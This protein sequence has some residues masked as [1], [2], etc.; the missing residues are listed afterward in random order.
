MI[1]STFVFLVKLF[2]VSSTIYTNLSDDYYGKGSQ[3]LPYS[4]LEE[5]LND[6][7]N[8]E[9]T[10]FIN[11]DNVISN[12]VISVPQ[13]FMAQT[14][15][16]NIGL[17]EVI[18]GIYALMDIQNT[19]NFQNISIVLNNYFFQISG[20]LF[21]ANLNITTAFI[22]SQS[23]QALFE[24]FETG[25]LSFQNVSFYDFPNV[26]QKAVITMNQ[27]AK[28]EI[29]N[30]VF[31]DINVSEAKFLIAIDSFVNIEN[32]SFKNF[33]SDTFSALFDL[34]DSEFNFTNSQFIMGIF[35]MLFN[36][37]LENPSTTY[38]ISISNS[39]FYNIS[40]SSENLGLS[41]IQI[42]SNPFSNIHLENL[43]FSEITLNSS[44][45]M[46]S[47]GQFEIDIIN[48]TLFRTTCQI[49]ISIIASLSLYLVNSSF[50]SNNFL[51]DTSVDGTLLTFLDVQEKTLDHLFIFDSVSY[52]TTPGIKIL[53][54]MNL[55]SF[56]T[57]VINNSYFQNLTTYF[58][59]E[60]EVGVVFY[61]SSDKENITLENCNFLNNLILPMLDAI[62]QL[63]DPC[64]R[65]MGAELNLTI[66][67][68][69]FKNNQAIF[70]STCIFFHGLD[71]TINSSDFEVN[72]NVLQPRGRDDI[73]A[74]GHGAI[75]TLGA[76]LTVNNSMFLQNMNYYGGTFFIDADPDR[77]NVAVNIQNS[78]FND[79]FA[80]T[81]G[82]CIYLNTGL[83][84]FISNF[85]NLIFFRNWAVYNA[86]GIQI[87][88]T[89]V[90]GSTSFESCIFIENW[91]DF[92]P[93]LFF[94]SKASDHYVSNCKFFNNTS[95][96]AARD[97]IRF[98]RSSTSLDGGSGG[99]V[100]AFVFDGLTSAYMY[101]ENNT[102]IDNKAA[103]K[104][105]AIGSI[106]GV[107]MN[108]NSVFFRTALDI[109]PML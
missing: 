21:F 53:S 55:F 78:V 46:I 16:T 4:D 101:F 58:A 32:S 62:D 51:N 108:K 92:G 34:T 75:Y 66:N 45:I 47:N 82:G 6:N 79:N 28:L 57:T 103:N 68:T 72:I 83:T 76:K 44:I 99:A 3:T 107:V 43:F 64:M 25:S 84:Y 48:V 95:S 42:E 30:S 69:I 91:S 22:E 15:I 13:T 85:S 97:N 5:A 8:K 52:L 33:G 20:N 65:V 94:E 86:G 67:Q 31:F 102:F 36:I 93:A 59:Q 89:S 29:K 81:F 11:N 105:G 63:G 37:K 56:S 26:C 40:Y 80:L 35:P 2:L 38:E 50:L 24:M 39:T 12:T 96:F 109:M 14:N 54:P 88:F 10:Y 1:I 98:K 73:R 104:G 77:A 49:G 106:G 41:L 90:A 17:S 74:I 100:G 87:G 7:Y 60:N 9:T 27:S 18:I 71:L 70:S 23:V 61:I 19:F